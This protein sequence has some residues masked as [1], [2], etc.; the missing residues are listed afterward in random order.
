MWLNQ[1]PVEILL[2][3][4]FT[5]DNYQENPVYLKFAVASFTEG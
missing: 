4:S 1:N 5:C 3:Q 2:S